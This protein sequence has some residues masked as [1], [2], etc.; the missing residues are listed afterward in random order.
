VALT[1]VAP[2]SHKFHRARGGVFNHEGLTVVAF[3]FKRV[4]IWATLW[5]FLTLRLRPYIGSA[6]VGVANREL[7]RMRWLIVRMWLLGHIAGWM[8]IIMLVETGSEGAERPITHDSD[9]RDSG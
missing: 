3:M 8:H 1:L 4:F 9:G 6:R 7:Q 5:R 2:F